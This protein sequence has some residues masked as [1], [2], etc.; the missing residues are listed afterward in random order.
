[1]QKKRLDV[2]RILIRASSWEVVNRLIK[3]RIDGLFYNIRVLEEPFPKFT[4]YQRKTGNKEA[5]SSSSD[6]LS[7]FS[8]GD[9]MEDLIDF[10]EEEDI[11]ELFDNQGINEEELLRR[12]ERVH[13]ESNKVLSNPI[14]SLPE[15]DKV[16]AVDTGVV[17]SQTLG[18]RQINIVENSGHLVVDLGL[19]PVN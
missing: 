2:A 12:D 6:S 5:S 4:F 11:Q 19:G 15:V 3:I 18:D 9:V 1:M 8:F 16:G 10:G 14:K 7:Y 13:E 17:G